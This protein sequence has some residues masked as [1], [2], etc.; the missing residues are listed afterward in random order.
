MAWCPE[1]GS[2][3]VEGIKVCAD[4]GC[5][6]VGSLTDDEKAKSKAAEGEATGEMAAAQA[7]T[8]GKEKPASLMDE[9]EDRAGPAD[10]ARYSAFYVNNEEKA[11][12][13]RTSAYTLL[14]VGG[15]GF[16]LDLLFFFEVIDLG[17]SVNS[18]YM[19]SGVMG[20]FFLLFIIMGAV[21]MKNARIFKKK[22]GKENNL[23]REIKKWCGENFKKEEIDK[24]LGLSGES[25]ELKYFQRF[26][27]IKKA[28]GKQFV[29]LDE[30]Y[31]DRLIEEIYPEIFEER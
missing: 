31:V 29:N 28:I 30:G 21:S 18:K 24:A 27:Y 10:S 15:I 4:C 7:C 8:E 9:T 17:M 2:E 14:F 1:C 5:E 6:L 3:Y 12:D 13:N 20:A 11:E 22:A 23:T 25:M 16:A 26:E 19:V